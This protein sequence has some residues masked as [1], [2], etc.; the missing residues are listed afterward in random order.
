MASTVSGFY[1]T[2]SDILIRFEVRNLIPPKINRA[3]ESGE[4]EICHLQLGATV[5]RLEKISTSE[6]EGS[7][8]QQ[9]FAAY[10]LL[11]INSEIE[12]QATSCKSGAEVV[13]GG[14]GSAVDFKY[15]RKQETDDEKKENVILMLESEDEDFGSFQK[16]MEAA[17]MEKLIYLGSSIAD[18]STSMFILID[19]FGGA[20]IKAHY[21]YVFGIQEV[22]G[23]E[24]DM[25]DLR[26]INLAKL[27]IDS[28][29]ND[30]FPIF[31][32]VS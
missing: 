19:N 21:S 12:G 28:V 9:R 22:D 31:S 2:T 15:G 6:P 25:T 1:P 7:R 11:R 24:Y 13:R 16:E 27:K 8:F 4:F 29:V 3:C 20:K 14:A 18:F 5:P 32:R 17:E 23:G 10:G 30:Q 26:T